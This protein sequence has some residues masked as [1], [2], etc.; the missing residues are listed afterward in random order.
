[1][2][3]PSDSG[4]FTIQIPT[5]PVSL[6][7]SRSK[8]DIVTDSIRSVT[9]TLDYLLTCDIAVKITWFINP[10]E[11]YE[12]DD[13]ADVDNIV[14]PILDALSG[15][16]G[17]LVNDCQVQHL[18]CSWV[19]RDNTPE[20]IQ[21][22]IEYE[23]DSYCRKDGILFVQ[24]QNALCIPING[25][26]SPDAIKVLLDVLEMQVQTRDAMVKRGSRVEDARGVL[27][28]Q[29][30]FHRTRVSEFKVQSIADLR[31]SIERGTW[32]HSE[33]Q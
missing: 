20:R 29:R 27:S 22:D 26:M 11:K 14:K 15:P 23:P 31:A 9:K 16:E 10:E 2:N 8:K 32:R 1:M 19:D 33:I 4:L 28:I 3:F 6:Q 21:I 25:N 12:S 13:P 24:I 30:F 17:I 5:K 18:M 7:A